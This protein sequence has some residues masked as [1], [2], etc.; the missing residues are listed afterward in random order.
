MIEYLQ[1]TLVEATLQKAVLDVNGIGYRLSIPLSTYEKLPPAGN[2]ILLYTASVI[3]EN[4][5]KLFAFS[6]LKER[7]LF[8]MVCEVSGIG[9]KIALALI[10][11]LEISKF[12]AA[13]IHANTSLLSKIP[14]IGKKT[15]ERLII[16]MKDKLDIR[17]KNEGH[18]SPFQG[19]N[20]LLTDATNA[21]INL[22]YHSLKAQK[23]IQRAFSTF[24]TPPTLSE[25]I[26]M[27]LKG[28]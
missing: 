12:E 18:I 21:L 6:T 28:I 15:A 5:H 1:G 4:S 27:A 22:G 17:L 23:A 9:P 14:G 10:G 25:L 20:I 24:E 16:E 7:D 3:R 13:I 2:K 19:K 26:G 11:H 8:E